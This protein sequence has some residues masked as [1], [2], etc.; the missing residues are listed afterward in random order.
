MLGVVVP[1]HNEEDHIDACLASLYEAARCPQLGGEE[2]VVVVALDNCSDQT[3]RIARGWGAAVVN[4]Q[5]RNV[6]VARAGGARRALDRGAR[7]LAFTDADSVVAPD[8]LST[9][10]RQGSDAVCGTIEVRDWG[11]YDARLRQQHIETYI[12]AD[13]HR[14]IHGANLGMTAA[15]YQKAGGFKPLVSSEDVALVDAL[16][17]SGASIAWSA[18]PR[19][20]TS[21]RRSYR[22]PGGFGETLARVDRELS[23]Q[24]SPAA[25]TE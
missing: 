22:A 1:A 24:R 13:G 17:D 15:A 10:L 9:Q 16:R 7:W 4:V 6:G 19:V 3:E 2:V 5:A 23:L 12:D 20:V 8:W 14:H 25:S 18:A 11:D 21:A